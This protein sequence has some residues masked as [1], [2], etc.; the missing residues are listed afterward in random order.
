MHRK[1]QKYNASITVNGAELPVEVVFERRRGHRFSITRQRIIMRLPLGLAASEVQ[2]RLYELQQWVGKVA[3][4]KTALLTP[5]TP[6]TYRSGDLL[7]VGAR[8]YILDIA[9]ED[10]GSHSGKLIGN[11]I[12]LYLSSRSTPANRN[13]AV[14]SLLSR[15]V[16][17]DFHPEIEQRVQ[18][19]NRRTFNRPLK[20]V[21]LKYNHSNWGSCSVNGNVNL[22]TRLLFAPPEVQDYIILHELAHLVELNHSDRFWALIERY[23]PDYAEK[24]KWLKTHGGAC[25]F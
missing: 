3:A 16:A 12:A 14:K 22:S 19:W 10:R 20:G 23:M 18:H 25:D 9:V 2:A 11:T 6:K 4:K 8:Q 5:F 15:I 1:S 17:S 7:T 21:F 13:K 24:E